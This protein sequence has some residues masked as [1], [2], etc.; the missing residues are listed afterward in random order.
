MVVGLSAAGI[1]AILGILVGGSAG[2]F[3]GVIDNG[4]MRMTDAFMVIPSFFLIL[5]VSATFGGSLTL[6]T[7]MIGLTTWPVAARLVRAEFLALREREFVLAER[8]LGS[9]AVRI[10]VVHLLPNA[11]PSLLAI[12]ALRAG[13]A[14]LQEASLSFLGLGDPNVISLGQVLMKALQF[15]RRAWWIAVF[16]G[17]AIFVLVLTFNLLSDGLNDALNPRSE[18][19]Y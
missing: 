12:S 8:A 18:E 14:I 9:G 10:M 17:M 4:L 11:L 13:G 2:Y 6:I 15:M 1:S 16:P 5:I 7:V 3:G 19:R